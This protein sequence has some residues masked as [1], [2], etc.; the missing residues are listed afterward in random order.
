MPELNRLFCTSF[1]GY[2]A[3]VYIVAVLRRDDRIV[4]SYSQ[5]TQHNEEFA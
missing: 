2:A 4:C 3:L 5:H 1:P